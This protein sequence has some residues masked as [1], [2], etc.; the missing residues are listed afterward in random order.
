MHS[1]SSEGNTNRVPNW[2]RLFSCQA[3]QMRTAVEATDA[4]LSYDAQG[5]VVTDRWRSKSRTTSKNK[6]RNQALGQ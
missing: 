5:L 6:A 4:S 1:I 2:E 3:R